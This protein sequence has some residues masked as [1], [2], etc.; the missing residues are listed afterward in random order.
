MGTMSLSDT[1][2]YRI[3]SPIPSVGDLFA[4]CCSARS[5]R[6]LPQY[7]KLVPLFS[8]PLDERDG[9]TLVLE[10]SHESQDLE[11]QLGLNAPSQLAS[12][13]SP[14]RVYACHQRRKQA[15]V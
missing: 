10:T 8:V 5:H 12:I 11:K 2:G 4:S 6:H 14:R 1:I 3:T 15:T 9:K 7:Y 13:L